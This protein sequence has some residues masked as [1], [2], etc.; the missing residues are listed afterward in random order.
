M[1]DEHRGDGLR[2]RAVPFH[3][4]RERLDPAE[5]Q[6]AVER[7]RHRAGRVLEEA[8]ALGDL[9]IAR[10][11]APADD[12]GVATEVLRGRVHD[13]VGAELQRTLQ[14]RRRERVVDDDAR[15]AR[16]R[17]LRHGR[18]VDDGER[19]IGRRLDPH[20][21]GAACHARA[22]RVE[23]GEIGNAVLARPRREHLRDQ[24]ERAAVR[25]VG[26]QH[27]V[28]GREQPQHRVLRGHAA[29]EREAARRAFERR[30][31]R[32]VR[33]AGGIAAAGVLEPGV[34]AHRALRERRRQVDRRHDRAGLRV[35]VLPHVD[36]AGLE[37]VLG[38]C[39]ARAAR[40]VSTSWLVR[41][42]TG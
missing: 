23:V 32:F 33:G 20:H 5:H 34:L 16:V 21:R 15:A 41:M 14:V 7:A 29:R 22:V 27:A 35:R 17:E 36:G 30:D 25:V 4:H 10:D 11:R 26:E 24:P 38:H 8:D 18:D 9:G 39:G 40:N 2:V 19:G 28:A 3:A 42:P 37:T 6:V 12:V 1:A 31:A 13:D